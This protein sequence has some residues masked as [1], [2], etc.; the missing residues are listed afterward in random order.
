MRR[1][2]E[3]LICKGDLNRLA[4]VLH[5]EL[6]KIDLR[7]LRVQIWYQSRER[8]REIISMEIDKWFWPKWNSGRSTVS[9]SEERKADTRFEKKNGW[10]LMAKSVWNSG[11]SSDAC[12]ENRLID[13]VWG[14]RAIRHI[15][16]RGEKMR[17][18]APKGHQIRA[19]ILHPAPAPL[20]CNS[21]P[22]VWGGG[23]KK[24]A[25]DMPY[26]ALLKPAPFQFASGRIRSQNSWAHGPHF[27][28]I[29]FFQ[30]IVSLVHPESVAF[31]Q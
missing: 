1:D 27:F 17:T 15:F 7:V 4:E 30:S 25:G 11:S 31:Y 20:N 21:L 13:T 3:V 12:R 14:S 22:P 9:G 29:S 19:Q 8:F 6:N 28:S 2:L 24:L 23:K 10:T 18:C 26:E 16:H 5:D